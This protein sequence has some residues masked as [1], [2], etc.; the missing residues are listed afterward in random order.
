[1]NARIAYL[2]GHRGVAILMVILY[3]AYARWWEVV[4]YGK[5]YSNM[6]PILNSGMFGVQLFF[7]ISGFV[8]LMTL[9]KC[10][11]AR[12]FLFRR[13]LRLF[14]AMLLCSLLI[15]VTAG[16]FHERPSGRPTF[17]SLVPPLTFVDASWWRQVPGFDANPLEVSYWSLYAEF[18]FYVVAATFYFWKGRRGLFA[19]LTLG[20]A[21]TVLLKVGNGI[22]PHA[23][24]GSAGKLLRGLGFENFGWFAAGAA[25]YTYSRCRAAGWFIAAAGFAVCSSVFGRELIWQPIVAGCVV[26]TVFAVSVI[27]PG[28]QGLLT[29]PILQF[30]GF[31]S[32]PLYLIHENMMIALIVKLDRL[33]L[34]IPGFL[35]PVVAVAALSVVAFGISRHGEQWVRA[36]I[37]SAGRFGSK[38][39]GC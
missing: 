28:V 33:D 16:F 27:H 11:S 2:D 29:H 18:K 7:L 31:I 38:A 3:H 13:W 26:A 34:G 8:I 1:M 36:R 12:E 6:F 20:F 22:W 23:G 35:L 5:K 21:S 15:F 17:P 30:F 19:A 10:T 37:R 24:L 14:P 32:Y 9:E 4:P 39:V 25:F